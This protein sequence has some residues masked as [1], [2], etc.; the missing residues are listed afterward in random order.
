MERGRQGKR[1][2]KE[3]ET[4]KER[5]EGGREKGRM[6]EGKQAVFSPD[7]SGVSGQYPF[8]SEGASADTP[9]QV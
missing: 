4:G 7:P 8:N 6:V 3:R 2:G 5:G 1:G 9:L